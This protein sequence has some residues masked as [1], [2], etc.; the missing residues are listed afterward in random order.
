MGTDEQHAATAMTEAG[1]GVEEV[2]G[3]VQS[4]D[5]LPRS[6]PAVDDKSA[7]RSRADD[8]VLVSLD[9]A[10]HVAHP[11]RPAATQAG[12]EGRLVVERSVAFQP[13]EGEHLGPVVADPASG[14]AIPAA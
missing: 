2:G 4:D 1:V 7:T 8:G 12:D 11:G 14:P 10:E 5:G 6:R 13:F 9:R 3:A